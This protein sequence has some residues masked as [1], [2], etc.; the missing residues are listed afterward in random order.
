[1]LTWL[2]EL[3]ATV[4]TFDRAALE[5]GFALR[6]TIGVAIPLVIAALAGKPSLGV[7][8][9]IGAFITGFTSLQGV[10]RTR[11]IAIL[12][13]ALGMAVT[14]F[15]GALSAHST[16]GVIAATGV[17]GYACGTIGQLGP[18]AATVAL[19]SL[20]AFVLFSS[21]PLTPQAALL[22]SALV[23][24]G[25]LV[26]AVLVLLA[27]PTERL[28]AERSAL[29]EV[30]QNLAEYARS[31]ADG[32]PAMPPITPF[33]TAR[34]VLADPQPFA[35]AAERARL[36]RLLEDSE[37]IRK[38]LGALAATH[39][40]PA[41]AGD[42]L[43]A[44]AGL[45][46]GTIRAE[47]IDLPELAGDLGVH[48]RD[49]VLAASM[50]SSGRLPNVHLL[51]KP[52]P[53]PY[54]ENHIEWLS[55][56]SLRSALVMSLA[57]VLGRH[58][59]ADRGYWIPM[60]AAIVLRPDFQTTFVRGFARIAGTLIG[61]VVATLL[62][63]LVRGHE[64]IQVA[65][66]LAAAAAAYLTFNPNYALFTVA[67]T[68]F[69][70]LVLSMRGLPGTTTIAARVLD[71]IAGGSLAMIGYLTLPTW[72]RKR[73]RALLVELLEAQR[74]LADAILRAYAA[75][76]DEARQR[77]ERDRTD[78]WRI[79]T[80]VEA[81]IDRSRHEPHRTHTIAV[82]RALRILAATQ[83]F[84]LAN[85]A[86]ESAL[87]TP[88]PRACA[89]ALNRFADALDDR[90]VEL[91]AALRE[92]RRATSGDRLTAAL[93]QAE[94]ELTGQKCANAQFVGDR[95]R[96][97]VDAAARVARLVGVRRSTLLED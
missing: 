58:F 48:L 21:Q 82:G 86:L 15:I 53:G 77:I 64:E 61:A 76:S 65:G 27:S 39:E 93:S 88:P 49:A 56:D 18:A 43:D 94:T 11:L 89:E 72:E 59:E 7:A 19:N 95:L 3:A 90:M 67:I 68:S 52:R 38:I 54:V 40:V 33:A 83:R 31:I 70:V 36:E 91:A 6:C 85:L 1:M 80:T 42:Q 50:L 24:G 23:L 71:T 20:V 62:L 10:Y 29:A 14:S 97:Y 44:I 73:T 92:S 63:R 28:G 22:Q 84:A 87:G 45:L 47:S 96:T 4:G 75:P 17:A 46:L 8:A 25:G 79:R 78:A 55:R 5:P 26:Q 41:S 13:A 32:S 66:V 51:S 2:R 35:R 57:M 60:T 69:V 16:I 37:L 12:S 9:A 34:Q 74:A 30:Y 81:S